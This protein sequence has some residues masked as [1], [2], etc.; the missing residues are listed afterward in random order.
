MAG[1][2]GL[3]VD[4][5]GRLL[6]RARIAVIGSCGKRVSR[7]GLVGEI[8]KSCFSSNMARI[9]SPLFGK[10]GK[11]KMARNEKHD[12]RRKDQDLE[13]LCVAPRMWTNR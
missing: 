4:R 12:G 2:G 13:L 1:A 5:H 10:S 9:F 6:S 7:L 8:V 11:R 3:G